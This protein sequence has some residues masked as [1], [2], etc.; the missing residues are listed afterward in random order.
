MIYPKGTKLVNLLDESE[1][2]TLRRDGRTGPIVVPG[3]SAK[4]FAAASEI[5]PLDPVVTAVSPAHDA[6]EVSP[7]APIVIHFSQPMDTASVEG[8]FSTE[9]SVEGALSWTPA[10]D[11]MTFTPKN[12]GFKPQTMVTMRLADTARAAAAGKTFYAGFESRYRCAG[13]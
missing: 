2:I 4:I 3:T 9:P 7:V 10:G 13:P 12:P 6:K 11:E 5:R 8:A 1:T